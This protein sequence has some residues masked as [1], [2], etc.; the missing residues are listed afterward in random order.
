MEY[1]EIL[2]KLTDAYCDILR[3]NFVGLY[4]H[5]SIALGCFNP[6]KSDIDYICVVHEEPDDESK[7]RIM[8]ENLLLEPFAPKKGLEMHVLRLVDCLHPAHPIPFCLH[9]SPAHRENYTKD[10]AGYVRSM[11]GND[12]DLAA[13]LTVM[14]SCG[15]CWKGMPVSEVFGAVPK[16]MYLDSILDDVIP[17]CGD[18]VTRICNL[19]R[20][21]GYLAEGLV[22]SKQT[23][24]LWALKQNPKPS[25]AIEE[26]LLC[27]TSNAQWSNASSAQDACEWLNAKVLSLLPESMAKRYR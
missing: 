19:C 2:D 24:A 22:L 18:E 23:G 12:P 10:P 26:A 4:V 7:L 14:H 13:H 8:Q 20:V 9:Y 3:K 16:E 1:S 17:G 27:Y 5:G 15:I 25:A 11:Q 21:W 6:I